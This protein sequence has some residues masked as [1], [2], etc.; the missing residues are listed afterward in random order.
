MQVKMTATEATTF[1]RVSLSNAAMAVM[2]LQHSGACKG[3]C[4]P[5]RDI[6][7]FRRWQA[8]GYTVRK[9]EHGAKLG[10]IANRSTE[11]QETGEVRSFSIKT[12][13]TVFCRC[14][15]KPLEGSR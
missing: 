6:Y 15:V 4:E 7:T 12:A 5:Y 14:Q 13:T 9:G 3:T 8:Q 1:D 10:V 2:Q 11:D